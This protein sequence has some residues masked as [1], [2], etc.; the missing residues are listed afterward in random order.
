MANLIESQLCVRGEK[1]SIENF[2]TSFIS[3]NKDGYS[4]DFD[5][6]FM[7]YEHVLPKAFLEEDHPG[8]TFDNVLV[9]EDHSP[10]FELYYKGGNNYYQFVEKNRFNPY[11][12]VN[13]DP[14]TQ[15]MSNFTDDQIILRITSKWSPPI[16]AIIH[17]S[18]QYP[19]LYFRLAFFEISDVNDPVLSGCVEGQKGIFKDSEHDYGFYHEE[20]K[21]P[22]MRLDYGHWIYSDSLEFNDDPT[23]SPEERDSDYYD[24]ESNRVVWKSR[25]GRWLYA[26]SIEDVEGPYFWPGVTNYLFYDTQIKCEEGQTTNLELELGE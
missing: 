24:K 14:H 21:R 23:F 1:D 13:P 11:S 7:R 17:L 4:F 5:R 10:N 19:E 20:S 8:E 22:I 12:W 6:L 9:L 25:S 2:K 3:F 26:D 18:K 15:D 16:Q